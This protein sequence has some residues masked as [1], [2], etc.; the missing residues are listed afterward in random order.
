V[1]SG[2]AVAAALLG[3]TALFAGCC[4]R[5]VQ[6]WGGLNAYQGNGQAAAALGSTTQRLDHLLPSLLALLTALPQA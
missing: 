4:M 3:W 1:V 5:L 6:A 2:S